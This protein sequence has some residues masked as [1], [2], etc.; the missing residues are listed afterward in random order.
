MVEPGLQLG[1]QLGAFRLASAA[2]PIGAFAYSQGLES[3]VAA[4][5]VTDA[6]SAQRWIDGVLRYSLLSLDIPLFVRLHRAFSDARDDDA[7]VWSQRLLAQRATSELRDEERQLAAALFRLLAKQGC[8][9]AEVWQRSSCR[10]LAAAHAFAA[11][12]YRISAELGA[13]GYAFAWAEAQVGAATRLIPLGQ[14]DAQSVLSA[15]LAAIERGLPGA[16][17]RADAEIGAT[18]PQQALLSA[19]HET[20]YSRL[21]RS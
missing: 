21:F 9:R 12:E 4:G 19:A 16:L 17:D 10:T 3:A 8:A 6:Q 14:T 13:A 2:L 11:H 7:R 5:L 20:L 18:T 1:A 15:L